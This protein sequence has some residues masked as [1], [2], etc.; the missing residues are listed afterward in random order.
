[1]EETKPLKPTVPLSGRKAANAL[2]LFYR[3]V[4]HVTLGRLTS[5]FNI[6]HYTNKARNETITRK[7]K[8]AT[9]W[10]SEEKWRAVVFDMYPD[11]AS[12][13]IFFVVET[14]KAYY[15]HWASVNFKRAA[16]TINNYI[17][18]EVEWDPNTPMVTRQPRDVYMALRIKPV[19]DVYVLW[20]WESPEMLER[21]KEERKK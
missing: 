5:G 9:S 16:K 1:M 20:N 18:E 3:E 15:E 8:A 12:W 11:G 4:A 6:L 19:E 2:S 10:G 14:D 7:L 17:A 21:F 13:L